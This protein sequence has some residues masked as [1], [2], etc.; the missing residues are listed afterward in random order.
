MFLKNVKVIHEADGFYVSAVNALPSA[1]SDE[2]KLSLTLSEQI[3]FEV[4][5]E[6]SKFQ[7]R[8]NCS[9]LKVLVDIDNVY[10][11]VNNSIDKIMI[12]T[13]TTT[14]IKLVSIAVRRR[15]GRTAD[16]GSNCSSTFQLRSKGQ[17]ER[18]S[19]DEQVPVVRQDLQE[20]QRL[21]EA[22]ENPH[23]REAVRVLSLQSTIHSKVD[24]RQPPEHPQPR[25]AS[26]A[27]R[28]ICS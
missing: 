6:G 2:D 11:V 18:R 3:L 10:N 1:L 12:I 27:F 9:M 5:Q 21:G 17:Q 26:H 23:R 8:F 7:V 20:A 4:K 22:R 25:S 19:A 28:S 16:D 14:I 15:L 13:I 24:S